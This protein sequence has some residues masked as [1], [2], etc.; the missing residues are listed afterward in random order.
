MLPSLHEID[1]ASRLVYPVVTPTA[2][3][4][5]PLLSKRIGAE[6]W[7]KHENH[8]P[9]GAFKVRGGLVYLHHL[10]KDGRIAEVI[11]ATRGNHGQSVALAARRFGLAST[12]VVP[13]GNSTGKNAA[14]RALGARLIEHGDEFQ[15]AREHAQ[16]L[17][18]ATGAH[19][20]PSFHPLLTRGVAT[21]AAEL[22]R[23]VEKLDRVY[24]PIGLGSYV[25]I[26]RQAYPVPRFSR[27]K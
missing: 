25:V 5:W 22:F 15:V 21:Y 7:L 20:V 6:V 1:D 27:L 12:I 18:T 10:A 24:V 11:A 4:Q 9:I 13:H 17:A 2:Q 16:A 8:T 26:I 19:M 23:H 3:Y 14:M